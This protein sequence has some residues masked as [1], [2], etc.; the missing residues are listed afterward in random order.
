MFI[1][2]YDRMFVYVTR[3]VPLCLYVLMF[4]PDILLPRARDA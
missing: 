1:R 3:Y 4:A 2:M